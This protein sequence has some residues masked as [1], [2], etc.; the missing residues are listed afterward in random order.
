MR[1][2]RFMLF[3]PPALVKARRGETEYGIGAIPLGPGRPANGCAP[4]TPAHVT[5]V[6]NGR[7]L[8]FA[9][10]PRYDATA[11]RTRIGFAFHVRAIDTDPANSARYSIDTMWKVTTA[12][13]SAI[14]RI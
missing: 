13:A 12:T 5:V 8:A 3:F 10:T 2:E 4:G 6:R 9:I 11:G 1:V 14:A 7:R